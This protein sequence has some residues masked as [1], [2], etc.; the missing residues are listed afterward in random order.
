MY[1][2]T[3]MTLLALKESFEAFSSWHGH[4]TKEVVKENEN[5]YIPPTFSSQTGV[6]CSAVTAYDVKVR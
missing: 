2:G 4:L 6:A 5:E 3:V 1:M